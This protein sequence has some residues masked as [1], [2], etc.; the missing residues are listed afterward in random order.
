MAPPLAAA[1]RLSLVHDRL[2]HSVTHT[3]R[4][5]TIR[6]ISIREATKHE[7]Q[8]YFTQIEN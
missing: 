1:Q 4:G 3:E 6:V 2:S 8:F 7:A 5:A